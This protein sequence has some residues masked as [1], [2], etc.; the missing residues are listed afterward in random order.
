MNT[1]HK[2]PIPTPHLYPKKYLNKSI[3]IPSIVCKT[4][5]NGKSQSQDQQIGLLWEK[6]LLKKH[7]LGS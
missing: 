1:S 2:Q 3:S 7:R 6:I 4:F 5:E